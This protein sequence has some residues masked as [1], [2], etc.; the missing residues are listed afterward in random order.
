MGTPSFECI[1]RRRQ[2]QQGSPWAPFCQAS[3]VAS[4]IFTVLGWTHFSALKNADPSVISKALEA[5][6]AE[7]NL[8]P[9]I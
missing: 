3:T 5:K 7:P 4:F 8:D 2:S 6:D 9:H 1:G